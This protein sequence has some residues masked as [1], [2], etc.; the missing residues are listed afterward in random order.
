LQNQAKLKADSRARGPGQ[1]MYIPPPDDL[2]SGKANRPHVVPS[3]GQPPATISLEIAEDMAPI[4]SITDEDIETFIY[5]PVSLDLPIPPATETLQHTEE[6]KLIICKS[7][8]AH[9]RIRRELLHWHS[10]KFDNA[11]LSRVPE[12]EDE[13]ERV[14]EDAGRVWRWLSVQGARARTTDQE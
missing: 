10:D 14:A 1:G 13:R 4:Q 7:K 9:H 11:V 3:A 5:D 12:D 8:A 6:A 2:R